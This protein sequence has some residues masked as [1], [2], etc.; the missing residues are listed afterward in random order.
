MPN[1]I[2][3]PQEAL[4][5]WML[6]GTIDVKGA[7]LTIVAEGRRYKIA[8]AVRV[9]REVSGSI[10]VNELVGKVKSKPY[11]LE[12]GAELLEG[13]MIMGDNAYDVVQGWTGMPVGTFLEHVASPDRAKARAQVDHGK[14]Q[15]EEPRTEEQLLARFLMK[16]L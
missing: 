14:F 15:P 5:Q 1:R 10:D 13:S 8:D 2:F 11:L 6:D 16:N 9:I 7:E 12:L 3:F 4:D